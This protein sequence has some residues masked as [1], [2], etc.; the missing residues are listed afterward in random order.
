MEGTDGGTLDVP[1]VLDPAGH[2]HA[3]TLIFLHGFTASAADHAR[4][5]L[6]RLQSKLTTDQIAALRLIFLSAPTRAVSCYGT[7]RPRLSAWHDYYTDHGGAGCRPDLEEEIDVRQLESCRAQ[8]HAVIT[9]EASV[10]DLSRIALIGTSQG[11]CVALD[12]ALTYPQGERLGGVFCSFGHLYTHSPSPLELPVERQRLRIAA[13]HGAADQ[14]I[15]ASLA[16]KSYARLLEAGFDELSLTVYP[17]LSHC[18]RTPGDVESAVLCEV[19]MRWGLLSI[20]EEAAPAAAKPRRPQQDGLEHSAVGQRC[21][22]LYHYLTR[23]ASRRCRWLRAQV[24][25]HGITD[26][27]ASRACAGVTHDSNTNVN[28]M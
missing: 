4:V 6:Q 18:K 7:P 2:A 13:F 22:R 26:G 27:E 5:T 11:G 28:I 16:L 12:A 25:R 20:T 3:S 1:V 14:C 23:R 15:A 21:V 9:S 24:P 19:L 8:I 10:V 17:G